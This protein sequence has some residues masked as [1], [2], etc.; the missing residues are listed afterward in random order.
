MKV[1]IYW[2]NDDSTKLFDLAKESLEDLGLS[3]FI[4]I[5]TSSDENVKT[6]LWI[7]AEPAFII[8]EESIEFKDVIFEGIVPEKE[9]I[10]S[11]FMSIIGGWE[12]QWGGDS[13]GSGGCWS[14]GSHCG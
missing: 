9:E 1:I 10:T 8:E 6:A 3:E 13:C 7:T 12:E 11:M 2:S 14:C 5:D 4:T